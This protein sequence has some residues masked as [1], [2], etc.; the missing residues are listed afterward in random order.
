[1]ASATFSCL[2]T[3]FLDIATSTCL[4][5]AP[6][7]SSASRSTRL[8]LKTSTIDHSA[9][10]RAITLE[11]TSLM[12]SRTSAQDTGSTGARLCRTP[13]S[14]TALQKYVSAF[15]STRCEPS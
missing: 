9:S 5:V 10:S 14:R 3:H 8:L 15:C 6:S 4:L 7:S 2:S 11:S 1:M 12:S 13:P